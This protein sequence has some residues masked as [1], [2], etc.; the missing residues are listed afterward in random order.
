MGKHNSG[1]SLLEVLLVLTLL[2]GAGFMLLFQIPHNLE[3]RGIEISS[4]RMV[5]DLREVQQAAIAENVWYRI[6]FYP[7]TNA[8]RIFRQ[9]ELVRLVNFSKGVQYGNSP[10]DLIF[11]PTGAPGT[12]M[13]VI[14]TSGNLE[15]RVIIAPVMG[16]IRLELVR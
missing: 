13:T 9:G 6:K 11:L 3:Q 2:A 10:Q 5:D 4:E 15:R 1:F 7:S 8:Y 14:L 16:R 12:G